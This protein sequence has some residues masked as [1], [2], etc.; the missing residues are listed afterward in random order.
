M[1]CPNCG[2]KAQPTDTRCMDCGAEIHRCVRGEPPPRTKPPLSEAELSAADA[3]FK[4]VQSTRPP[5][6]PCPRC[7]GQLARLPLS[8]VTFPELVSFQPWMRCTDCGHRPASSGLRKRPG[9]PA[10]YVGLG[11]CPQCSSPDL[12]EF[13][14]TDSF[15][16]RAL[17]CLVDL[18]FAVIGAAIGLSLGGLIGAGIGGFAGLALPSPL[19]QLFASRHRRCRACGHQWPV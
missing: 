10:P 18:A 3:L 13:R 4:R 8:E 7:G 16:A 12:V 6:N 1:E 14:S 11:V 19:I 2:A 17:C 9:S 15:S 5:D